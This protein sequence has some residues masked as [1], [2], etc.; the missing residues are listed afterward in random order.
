MLEAFLSSI[1]INIVCV[2]DDLPLSVLFSIKQQTNY[3]I[4]ATLL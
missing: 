1:D 3:G 2:K 4:L